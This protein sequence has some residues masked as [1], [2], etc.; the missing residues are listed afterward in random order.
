MM[1]KPLSA[2]YAAGMKVRNKMF[3]I[4]VL[5]QRVFDIPVIVVG[6]IAIGGTGKTPHAEYIIDALRYRFHVG[7]LSRGYRRRTKG[8]LVAGRHS[9]PRDIGDEPYQ[10]YRKFGKDITLGVCEDRCRGIDELRKIDPA[11]NLVV[12]DD[13]FQHRYVKPDVA[14]VL[15]EYGRPAFHDRILPAG[16]LRESTFA[17]NRADIVIVTKC[18]DVVKPMDFRLFAKNL[19]LYPYQKLFFSKF[20]YGALVPV[21]PEEAAFI[22]YLNWLGEDETI[23]ALAGIANPKPFY[24]YLRSFKAKVKRASFPDHHDFSPREILGIRD[25]FRAIPGEKKYIITT[26]KDAVRLMSIPVPRSIRPLMFYLPVKVEFLRS[27]M[28]EAPFD[29]T[30]LKL[31]AAKSHSPKIHNS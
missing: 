20:T 17:F 15:T 16:R 30:L 21:F 22:P 12:L 25:A 8:F 14:I 6:N 13:A 19:N 31:I 18:P 7:V 11:I 5:K 23:L 2:L 9:T 26:E 29:D 27:S 24:R 3:D 10:M 1:L 4:G 28:G